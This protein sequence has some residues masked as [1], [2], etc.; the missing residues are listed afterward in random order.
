MAEE[1]GG[2]RLPRLQDG[3]MCK[4]AEEEV[5]EANGT[6]QGMGEAEVVGEEGEG[7]TA[8]I[9]G[10]IAHTKTCALRDCSA[11]E[12]F[13]HIY[14]YWGSGIVVLLGFR[15]EFE[16]CASIGQDGEGWREFI[17]ILGW[18]V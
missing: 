11:D 16:E 10:E 13:I 18:L 3:G 1:G 9:A 15:T 6:D 5:E 8:G 17:H 12:N 7:R 4:A 2:D 14:L